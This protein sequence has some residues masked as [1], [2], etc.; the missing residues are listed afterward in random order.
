MLRDIR[1]LANERDAYAAELRRSYASMDLG[2]VDDT[3]T[4]RRDM[5]DPAGGILDDRV[6]TVGSYVFG[7]DG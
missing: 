4:L 2:P 1:E 7:A 5:R 6:I 3:V